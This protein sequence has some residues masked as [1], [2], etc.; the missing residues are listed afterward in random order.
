MGLKMHFVADMTAEDYAFQPHMGISYLSAF[1][2]ENLGDIQVTLSCI[3]DNIAA[4]IERIRPDIIGFSCTSRYFAQFEHLASSLKLKF[5]VPLLFGGVHISIAPGELP[6]AADIGVIGEGEETLLELIKNYTG[7]G[8]S[9][10]ERIKGITYRKDGSLIINPRREYIASLDKVPSRDLSL[11]MASWD[12][13]HR[14]VMITSRGCPYKCHF[15]ASSMFWDRVRLHSARYVINE[16]KKLEAR[17]KI[18]E[19]LIFDDF[20]S[21]DKKRVAE[22]VEL[23]KKEPTLAGIRFES[24]SRV[25]SFDD[26]MAVLLKEMGVYRVS[27]GME[28]GCQK[29]LDYLKN[30]KVRLE[31]ISAAVSTAQK[32]GF[33]CVGSFIIGSPYESAEDIRETFKFIKGLGLKSV[34]ITIATPFPGTGLWADGQAVGKITGNKWSEDYYAL[35]GIDPNTDIR[36]LLNGK[37]LL[38]QIDLDLFVSLAQ[39]AVMLQNMINYSFYGRLRVRLRGLIVSAGLGFLIRWRR[40]FLQKLGASEP[41]SE[42]EL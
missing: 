23:K 6:E 34:Q 8:F 15:C 1:L 37:R 32:Y 36:K 16:M 5:H 7:S 21:I 3:S 20:F 17:F 10:I 9:N 25:D 4:D 41:Q 38:T 14:A 27:F 31:Q 39:D 29:T 33:E 30:K 40:R 11:R 35:F 13:D 18:R 19:I 24:T 12:K 42:V 28:S 2:K 26:E 22:I